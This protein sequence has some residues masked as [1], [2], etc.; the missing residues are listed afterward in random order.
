MSIEPF[1]WPLHA[2]GVITA[3]T[4]GLGICITVVLLATEQPFGAVTVTV[5][6]PGVVVLKL[7]A[8]PPIDDH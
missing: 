3:V 8:L 6:V 7:A 5:N 1:D 2:T 4:V